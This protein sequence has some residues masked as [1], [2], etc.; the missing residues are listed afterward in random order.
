[1][2]FLK[3]FNQ[4]WEKSGINRSLTLHPCAAFPM[5]NVSFPP[6]PVCQCHLLHTQKNHIK[7]WGDPC[8]FVETILWL[9]QSAR[10]QLYKWLV[11]KSSYCLLF[12]QMLPSFQDF[13]QQKVG[14]PLFSFKAYQ[15]AM[16][17]VFACLKICFLLLLFALFSFNTA[18]SD[19]IIWY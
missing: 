7:K 3:Q 4:C 14:I 18:C 8:H 16:V 10:L 11:L 2:S 1:M 9:N 12:V 6:I 5:P 13:Q 15:S 17:C 19:K